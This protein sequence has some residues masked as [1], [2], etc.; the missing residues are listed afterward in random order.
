MGAAAKLNIK[1]PS[2]GR[3][4]SLIM[5]TAEPRCHAEIRLAVNEPV[6]AGN[7][8][9]ARADTGLAKPGD[10]TDVDLRFLRCDRSGLQR[11]LI[12]K[13]SPAARAALAKRESWS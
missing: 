11:R 7:S 6:V 4:S 5:M 13:D 12:V 10:A 8:T 1:L 2:S 3:L 9:T